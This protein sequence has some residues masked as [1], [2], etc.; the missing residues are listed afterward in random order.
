MTICIAAVCTHEKKSMFV[1]ATDHMNILLLSEQ[2]Y[3]ELRSED[4]QILDN[5]YQREL[6]FGKGQKDLDEIQITTVKKT[7][8]AK[9]PTKLK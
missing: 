1:I 7:V 4:L 5:I 6:S 2:D 9:K 8:P 3:I